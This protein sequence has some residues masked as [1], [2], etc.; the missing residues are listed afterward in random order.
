MACFA[1]RACHVA[2]CVLDRHQCTLKMTRAITILILSTAADPGATAWVCNIICYPGT[3]ATGNRLAAVYCGLQGPLPSVE[4][5][6]ATVQPDATSRAVVPSAAPGPSSSAVCG[7]VPRQRG[8]AKTDGELDQATDLREQTNGGGLVQAATE[9]GSFRKFRLGG[10]G[11]VGSFRKST[12]KLLGKPPKKGAKGAAPV[13]APSAGAAPNV[14]S[15]VALAAASS[16]RSVL[17]LAGA[18]PAGTSLS[19]RT[20]GDFDA[21][22]RATSSVEGDVT[23]ST[24]D[25][26]PTEE[27]PSSL[28]RPPSSAPALLPEA[29][30]ALAAATPTATPTATTAAT[31]AATPA[32]TSAA[33]PE[34]NGISLVEGASTPGCLASA[35]ASRESTAATAA[36]SPAATPAATPTATPATTPDTLLAEG[37]AGS[38]G[39]LLL[40]GGSSPVGPA[41]RCRRTTKERLQDWARSTFELGGTQLSTAHVP[42]VEWSSLVGHRFLGSGKSRPRDLRAFASP[43]HPSVTHPPYRTS[44]LTRHT[45][46]PRPPAPHIP[47][48]PLAARR[49]ILHRELSDARWRASGCQGAPPGAPVRARVRAE[50]GYEGRTPDQLG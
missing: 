22:P 17:E 40:G 42:V 20:S 11:F 19:G 34:L 35:A 1:F 48:A 27:P 3:G 28:Q 41:G 50:I 45:R 36:A 15:A 21:T 38:S 9:K 7:C 30:T 32:A 31:P 46:L 47:P 8:Q 26:V 29:P 10:S 14:H 16:G 49:R 37:A 6:M 2:R 33:A 43:P 24:D 39:E 44:P 13:A 12:E 25:E 4:V 18:S 23:P 5:E